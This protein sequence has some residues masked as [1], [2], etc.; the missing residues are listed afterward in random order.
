MEERTVF[1]LTNGRGSDFNFGRPFA[2]YQ[3]SDVSTNEV[4]TSFYPKPHA[5]PDDTNHLLTSFLAP[6]HYYQRRSKPLS[7]NHFS[8]LRY[9]EARCRQAE[10]S[11]V[12]ARRRLMLLALHDV[13]AC[14]ER[15]ITL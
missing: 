10:E 15:D 2:Y 5:E 13:K 9:K 12:E 11:P 14:R 8:Y 4:V 7:K 6:S 3:H 1:S